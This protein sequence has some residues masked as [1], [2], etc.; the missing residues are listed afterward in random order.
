[1]EHAQSLMRHLAG[2][3]VDIDEAKEM[4]DFLRE[5]SEHETFPPFRRIG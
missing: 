3:D 4:F 2:D 1:M 5:E